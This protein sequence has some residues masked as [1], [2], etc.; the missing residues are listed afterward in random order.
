MG[1]GVSAWE[2][3]GVKAVYVGFEVCAVQSSLTF[4][5]IGASTLER[6]FV[7]L[8]LHMSILR[9]LLG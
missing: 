5:G 7:R 3:S 4:F 8:T 1:I 9:T 6:L 2:L